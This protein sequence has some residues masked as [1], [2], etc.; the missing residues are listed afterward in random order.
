MAAAGVFEALID[1]GT[2]I[3][4]TSNR[5]P[6]E[7]NNFG[8]HETIFDHFKSRLLEACIAVDVSCADFRRGHQVSPHHSTTRFQKDLQP[9]EIMTHR[10][11]STHW[12]QIIF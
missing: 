7:L 6:W 12:A 5:A 4:A 2:I 3:V 11:A 8:V 1:S 10:R 9:D